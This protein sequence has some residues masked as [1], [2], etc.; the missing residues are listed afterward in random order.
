MKDVAKT[1]GI[2]QELNAI[3]I[4]L[5][6]DDF[7]TGYSSLSYLRKFPIAVLKI[8]RSFVQ[9][10]TETGG[11]TSIVSAIIGLG[12]SLGH[13]VIAEGVET[14]AQ[15]LYLQSR[16]CAMGQGYLFG[17]PEPADVTKR[18]LATAFAHQ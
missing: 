5:G 10:I 15:R 11:N 12:Q 2:L 4:E 13:L 1:A 17:R 8:D 16:D 14:E 9:Q 3:G 18:L 7:G 6:V